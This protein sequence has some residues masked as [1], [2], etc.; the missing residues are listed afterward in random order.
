MTN[1]PSDRPAPPSG[2]DRLALL[3][4]FGLLVLSIAAVPHLLRAWDFDAPAWRQ[5]RSHDE[6][7]VVKRSCDRARRT[8]TLS[9]SALRQV[10]IARATPD[11][12][13]Q[14]RIHGI[15]SDYVR[16]LAAL[17]Y[18]DLDVDDVVRLHIHSVRTDF[19]R[20]LQAHGYRGL[21]VDDLVQLRIHDVSPGFVEELGA[22][23][24][25]GLDAADLV[26]L[27]IHGVTPAFVREMQEALDR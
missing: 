14:L 15:R 12:L 23:G 9:R 20:D 21:E 27:R 25:R 11:D 18:D 5:D 10:G 1:D 13:V 17:G 2:L 16:E 4:A 22:L 8:A 6:V 24:L 3:A 19:I 7:R 26:R